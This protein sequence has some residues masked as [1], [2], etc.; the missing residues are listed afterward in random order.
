LTSEIEPTRTELEQHA[1]DAFGF[2]QR[3]PGANLETARESYQTL[4]AYTL[5]A[6]FFEL[7][8]DWRE[9]AVFLLVGR[10]VDGRRPAGYYVD[11]SG[12]KVRWHLGA[13]LERGGPALRAV[14]T[15]L[16]RRTRAAGSGRDVMAA[17]IDDQAA[18]LRN[19]LPELPTLLESMPP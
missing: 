15:D 1:Q 14:A 17:R 13:V 4:L 8:L 3:E 2:L 5:P 18:A 7:E 6:L 16:R 10:T 9:E 19:A 12:Q 11:P